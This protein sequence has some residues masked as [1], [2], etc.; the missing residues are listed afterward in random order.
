VIDWQPFQDAT[1]NALVFLPNGT[2]AF[3]QNSPTAQINGQ[4]A[5]LNRILP[6]PGG[7]A[8][9]IN[10]SVISQIFDAAGGSSIGGFVA[11]Y[12]PTGIVIG[13][14]AT[15]DVGQLLLTTLDVPSNEEF[16]NFVES[17][18]AL[19]LVGATNSTAQIRIDPGSQINATRDNAFF[20]AVAA[21][22]QMSGTTRVNGSQAFVAGEIV[23]LTFSNGLFN[24][25]VP[26]GTAAS[27]QVLTVDGTVGGPSSLGV[28][29]NH[30]IY[31][32]ARASKD[33]IS[34]LFSGN[35]GFDPAQTAGVVNGE[36]ILAANYDVF[37][38]VVDGGSISQG[39]AATFSGNTGFFGPRADIVVQDFNA[40]SSLLAIG[41][42]AAT[43]SAVN[44]DSSVQGNLL[45]VGRESATVSATAGF[46][47]LISGDV[48]VDSTEFAASG[49]F[50]QSLDTINATGGNSLIEAGT[51][52]VITINGSAQVLADAFA[53]ADFGQSIAGTATGGTAAISGNGGAV[54]VG[55][56]GF[57]S[58]RGFGTGTPDI[59]TGAEVR[60]GSAQIRARAGG[61]VG[62]VQQASV[63]AG[64]GGSV[65]SLS[66][67]ST[68]SNAY[69]GD[70]RIAVLDGGGTINIG[71][72]TQL[73]ASAF[74]GAANAVGTGSVGDGGEATVSILDSG[75]ITLGSSL[76]LNA[77]GTGGNNAGGTGGT[78]LGGRASISTFNGGTVQLTGSLFADANGSGGD[79]ING[80]NGFG[81]IA[82]ANARVGSIAITN[83][84]F[85]NANGFG[86]SAT[87]DFGG[88][89]GTGRGGN[90]Y[91][92][93]DGTLTETA[94][95][96][97]N[98]ALTARSNGTG[99][100]GG[101]SDGV[102]IAA[103]RGGDGYGGDLGVP[104]QAG[105]TVGSGAFAIAGGDNGTLVIAGVTLS[106]DGLAGNGGSAA[107]SFAGGA[108]G[109]GFGGLAQA[110]LALLGLDGSVGL[111]R[112][113]LGAINASAQGY[114]G[115]SGFNGADIANGIGGNATGGFAA[116]TL[117]AG[118]MT[119]A[120]ITL[121][122]DGTG[123]AGAA[124]GTG[125]GGE[126]VVLGSLGGTL[127][128]SGLAMT[129]SGIGGASE[130]GTGGA[131]IGG[132]SGIL[133]N[134]VSVTING[135]V[136]AV[137]SGSGGQSDDG[138]GGNGSG[139][140]AYI[141]VNTSTVGG[142]INI[143]GHASVFAFGQGG[144]TLTAFKAGD[145]QGGIASVEATGGT[146]TLGS[147]Q[148][149]SIGRGG[150]AS[151]HKGGNGTGGTVRLRARGSN[152]TLTVLR[153]VPAAA[154]ARS[155]AS[156]N[157]LNANGIGQDANGGDGIGG[158]GQG[159]TLLVNAAQGGTINLPVNILADPNRAADSLFMVSRGFGGNSSVD[160]GAG[161]SAVGGTA[162]MIIDG[163]TL[164]AGPTT[165]STFTQG[166]NSAD[167]LLNIAGGN[168]T[169]GARTIR[170]INGGVL[171]IE[172]EGGGA[173]AQGG[174]GSGTSNGGSA[175]GGAV[176]FEVLNST[177]NLQGDFI[178]FNNATGG[179][180][181]QGGFADA[182]T[183]TFN[184]NNAT[185][186][187]AA[188][189]SGPGR[190]ALASSV[191]GGTGTG[192]GGD[193]ASALISASIIGSSLTGG[194]FSIDSFARGGAA[195]DAG[196]TGG[197]A[198]AG[199]VSL[200]ATNSTL[201][202]AGTLLVSSSAIGGDGG[203]DT[204]T[205]GSG[206]G[207]SASVSLNGTGLTLVT[208]SLGNPG[209]IEIGTVGSAGL[210]PQAGSARG[211]TASFTATGGSISAAAV[212][213]NAQAFAAGQAGQIGGAAFGGAAT[214]GLAGTATLGATSITIN[215]SANTSLGGTAFGGVAEFTM[216]TGSTGSLTANAMSVLADATG[217][218]PAD[219]ANTAGIFNIAVAGGNA[220]LLTLNASA[221][222]DQLDADPVASRISAV[223][224]NLNVANQIDAFTFGDLNIEHGEN[225]IIGTSVVAGTTVIQLEA[226]GTLRVTGVVGGGGGGGSA[227]GSTGALSGRR[228]VARAGRS[229]LIDGNITA[230]TG[231]I[232]LSANNGGGLPQAQPQTS[233][234]TMA[235]GSLIDG[236]TGLVTIS[237][238]DGGSD[239]QRTTGAITL[240]NITAGTINVNQRGTTPGSDII[241]LSDGVLTA[242]DTGRAIDLASYGGEVINQH[243]DA[244]LILTGG[245]HFGVYA[246]TPTGSQIG[247]FA[248]YARFYNV[249]TE[250]AYDGLNPGGNF[251]A[252]R[253]APVLTVT[254]N[255]V[256]RFYGNANPTF[257]ST[258]S[259]FLPGDGVSDLS[260]LLQ[261]LTAADST[262]PTGQYLLSVSQGTLASAQGYTFN[263]VDATLT[264]T[265]RPIT[266]T[267]DNLSRFYGDPDPSLTYTIGG[268]GLANGDQ[269]TGALA[270]TANLTSNV[271]QYV[272]GQGTLSATNN[273]DVTFVQGQLTITP[274]PI[275]I[276]A[277]S[278]SRIYGNANPALTYTVGGQGL[279]N[280]D[281]LTG[282]LTT[283][284]GLTS[285]TGNYAI[286]QGT[287]TAGGNYAIT[288]NAGNLAVTARPITITADNLSRIYGD[289]NPALTYTV[290][291]QGLVNGDQIGGALATTA[292]VTSGIGNYGITQ[293][294]LTAGG[295]YSITYNA[296]QLTVTPRPI[297]VTADNLSRIYGNANPALTYVVGGQGLVNGDQLTGALATLAGLTSGVG[298]YAITQGT[299]AASANYTLSFTG[300]QLAVTPR[301]ITVTADNLSRIYGNANPALTYTVG[302]QG[303]ANGDQLGGSLATTA[304]LTSGIGNYAIT[305][306]SL[307][308]SSNYDLTFVG[309]QLTVTPRPITITAS[310]LSRQYGDAN[311]ALTFTVGGQGLVNGDQLTGALTTVA[312][313]TTGI[314]NYAITQGTLAA[315]ANYAV[316]YNAGTLAITP[317]PI[318]VTADSF[319]R[320]YGNANPAL[321]FVV[322]GQGLVN[323]D[324]LTGALA[325]TAGAT[326]GVGAYSITQGTLAA[327][328]NYILSYNAGILTINPR[329]IT[330][331]ASNLSRVY[332][333]ANPALTFTVGGQGLVNGDQI[334][335]ALA[336]TAG[337]T[338]GVGNYGIT[339]GTLTAGGNYAITYNAGQLTVTPRPITVTAD[340]L[341][342]VYGNANPAL[343]FVVGG[344]GLVNGDQLTGAL[345]TTA[346]V[347]TGVG[348][349][350][351]TQGTLAASA[352]YT[353]TYNAGSLSITP[354]PITITASNLSRVYGDGNPALT[355]TVGGQ[356]L[357]NGDQLTGALA[358]TAGATTGVGSVA[359][360]QGTLAASANYAVTYN[361]GVL[362]ITPR[363]LTITANSF[364]RVYGNA[365][366]AL[367]FMV[368]GQGLVNGDQLTGALA[369]AG[370]TAGVG[371]SAITIGTLAASANYA[372]TFNAGVLTITPRP[373]TVAANNQSKTLGFA[374]PVL[375]FLVTAGDLV[376]GDQLT[377]LLARDP[378]E[379]I[380]NF[381]IRQG[382]L[383]AGANYTLTYVPGTFTINPPPV[384][385]DINNPTTIEPALVAAETPP[386]VEGEEEERFGIDFPERPDAPLIS[387]DPLLDDPVASGG[388][389]SLY[390]NG[391]GAAPNTTGGQ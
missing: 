203:P 212:L 133:A 47:L 356:G 239:P 27:G 210:G 295:N 41:T 309:G 128:A 168:A 148:V 270:S 50:V 38:R 19:P 5:V 73:D 149:A 241:V 314:G 286:T 178:L 126:T 83:D 297:T 292:G 59:I 163:G 30:M 112:A 279:V 382:T 35:L 284:A 249:Q 75:L 102:S 303:L 201:G 96:T 200:G 335:G 306:G 118:D 342:R 78:G 300:G 369:A 106:A 288:Y 173:G 116:V 252:F 358:T 209:N 92:Q 33:P 31:G 64:A 205:G 56:V 160:G 389:S 373:L 117:R 191:L 334:G 165:M 159:G 234:F 229:F 53:G 383:T 94:T 362:T 10:G 277:D 69:G 135:D 90:A 328:A 177:A 266:I 166:G 290:G 216:A 52:S 194:G 114:G 99:G 301:P 268:L 269:L 214:L 327:T 359:I 111:G 17:G 16:Q 25:E 258:I 333:D 298:S 221:R 313:V 179:N 235:Q 127:V 185:I 339:Q 129:A 172:T 22:I 121:N 88:T 315:S 206:N 236:G 347:T 143:T 244:G 238:Q 386:P 32:V 54:S 181:L 125:T 153:N 225:G 374:D 343:T 7:N 318:T 151:T 256:S 388:D 320:I 253:I 161:G 341:T 66:T 157:M 217:G 130:G 282:A 243:G 49:S 370:V 182:G 43:V 156:F 378:G 326:S 226:R 61:S 68:L 186:N 115:R 188:G 142:T 55:G 368:G 42:H 232:S 260:G 311:P 40:S 197:N 375:T 246:A 104:N 380:G 275:T 208:D 196:S 113:N 3:Y 95:V 29:D 289:A 105:P 299:L 202:L 57:V 150:L 89:G 71:A 152:S 169:G 364:S 353:L 294:T 108:G 60:G 62:I 242:S 323:G 262:T 70:A 357:A 223:V 176:L 63:F 110:G 233:V 390:G 384:S 330:I 86:G 349:Y 15:F 175:R 97:V 280:G 272:I 322:G 6:T 363:P 98:G 207:G 336:T 170:V 8:A 291:G 219:L 103:G 58:A 230:T 199:G 324:Q 85:A 80:G 77:S 204:G 79:G 93:A 385:P 67:P 261:Y 184:A 377:G 274:R 379:T 338:S 23:N 187:L 180:G 14:T 367:T 276:T 307:V 87:F 302:G 267:A 74:G 136:A 183:I 28:G 296:G 84:V 265:P 305:Q 213:L 211:G 222:G 255:N 360:T 107:G 321:T 351:I 34:M 372:V 2:T 18:A 257:S 251:A 344:Q 248:N 158:F 312:G 310:D 283:L 308:A 124:A 366:P 171:T 145:G 350:A 381:V 240:A 281:Q 24:I 391:G 190:L 361:A 9:V 139:G 76:F 317:R 4:F 123:G 119:A 371:N 162:S 101:G 271:G 189:V 131:G 134:G 254:A 141:A 237:L 155:P 13:N 21:N 245:G 273:Y 287:L 354:R 140:S 329:P 1:G 39:I 331:T 250:L 146:V 264:I 45:V 195:T 365:N 192:L 81:G 337:L 11:F 100:T 193:A 376:N 227:A 231:G 346:G 259:G 137:A 44:A 109:D 340:S 120:G 278:F 12:S 48:L 20:A 154:T 65:G 215:S 355:F 345:A 167:P 122:A 263:F 132:S 26:L 387:E 325:T 348:S 82:G 228:I 220:N 147:V 247:S 36:I 285:G 174:N 51:G 37:G 198:S 72:S 319:T 91:L 164:V 352:N 316:T 144:N 293:G 332:G 138:L 304:G 218:D 224:G 46:D